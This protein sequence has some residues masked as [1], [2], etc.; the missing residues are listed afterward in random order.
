[1]TTANNIY[2]ADFT[3]DAPFQLYL[4]TGDVL[5]A[6]KVV[7]II[8]KKRMVVF[9]RWQDKTI[10][11]KL[12]F[13]PR[14]AAQHVKNELRGVSL[15]HDNHIPTPILYLQG[16]SADKN[17]QVLIF[18]RIIAAQN[19]EEMWQAKTSVK[20][21]LPMLRA[22][23]IE[24]ATQHVFGILQHDLHFK[25]FLVTPKKI[26]TLDGA[27]IESF[28][29]K[30]DKKI[31]MENLAL[32]LSQ[33]GVGFEKYQELLF[34]YYAKARG[35]ILKPKDIKTLFWFV[36]K[37]RDLRWE[38]FAK[39]ITRAS[40]DFASKKSWKS[41]SVYD[42]QYA[43][44]EFL[45]MLA[46]PD[47]AYHHPSAK[48]LKAGNSSTVIRVTLDGRDY[49]VKR[50]NVKNSWHYLRRCLRMTRATRSWRLAQKL[51]LNYLPTPAPVAFIEKRCLGLK[52]KSYYVTTY[53]A[54]QHVGE[55]FSQHHNDVE[56]TTTMVKRLVALFKNFSA[57]Y[58]SHGDLKATNIL[59]DHQQQPL[60]L[61]FDGALEH[62]SKLA[63]RKTWRKEI[64]RFLR[65]FD[66]QPTV[67]AQFER[68]DFNF[69]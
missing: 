9:G 54:G 33:L 23:M 12:F 67:Q 6:E 7:R 58:L 56:K 3:F 14:R 59:I 8:P 22:M 38:K 19:I 18:E 64:K 41:W 4:E 36:R 16:K 2:T 51:K 49:V 10:V 11:A 66:N 5:Y 43:A 30:L 53:V 40:T 28:P 44:P 69:S 65:N 39:K 20:E 32:F 13:D 25:N 45:A 31:S 57:L 47:T 21:C 61:D 68:E 1:V 52:G 34:R 24:L 62:T 15:L 46:N 37:Q 35:W 48:I 42:R 63:L 17:C 60:L 55:F 27:Q 26:Y 50:Y 29:A